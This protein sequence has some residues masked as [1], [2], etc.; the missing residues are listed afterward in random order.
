MTKIISF[1]SKEKELNFKVFARSVAE[2]KID[3]ATRTLRDLIKC[4]FEEAQKITL[5]FKK[6]FEE[7]PNVMMQM[8][9][10][11]SLLEEGKQNDAL[12]SIQDIFGVNGPQSIQILNL[13]NEL[14]QK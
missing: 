9:M 10:I 13:M 3:E 12:T 11:R 1:K 4:D 8:M 5:H 7:S 14:I 6:R 2:G